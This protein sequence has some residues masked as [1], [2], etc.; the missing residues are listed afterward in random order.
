MKPPRINLN[1]KPQ[2]PPPE[3][4]RRGQAQNEN[5]KNVEGFILRACSDAMGR[6]CKLEKLP[7]GIQHKRGGGIIRVCTPY[8]FAGAFH[9]TGRGLFID[10]KHVDE[11]HSG[12]FDMGA[13]ETVREHQIEALVDVGLTG[14]A[15]GLIVYAGPVGKWLWADWRWLNNYTRANRH[16]YPKRVGWGD[17]RWYPIGVTSG[18]PSLRKIPNLLGQTRQFWERELGK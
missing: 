15:A 1:Q 2:T 7:N 4:R 12:G 6:V 3:Y 9:D 16:L 18:W 17:V 14:A 8:D 13:K 11:K 10:A 5:A